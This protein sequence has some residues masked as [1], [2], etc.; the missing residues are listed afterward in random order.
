MKF[1]KKIFS[2]NKKIQ[3]IVKKNKSGEVK[4][5]SLEKNNEQKE[6]IETKNNE[7]KK[8]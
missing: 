4:E 5:K 6:I 2:A 1:L 7:L 3:N 8:I